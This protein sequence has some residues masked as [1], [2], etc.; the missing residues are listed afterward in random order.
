MIIHPSSFRPAMPNFLHVVDISSH[1]RTCSPTPIGQ[2][3]FPGPPAWRL[4]LGQSNE[5]SGGPATKD[6]HDLAMALFAFEYSQN[7]YDT[8]VHAMARV[9][10]VYLSRGSARSLAARAR[11]C[12]ARIVWSPKA[13]CGCT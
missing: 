9:G 12:Q 5:L 6:A 8:N 7:S 13:R 10:C 4:H 1:L 11:E 2:G 3:E